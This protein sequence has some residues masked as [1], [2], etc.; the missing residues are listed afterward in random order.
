MSRYQSPEHFTKERRKEKACLHRYMLLPGSHKVAF[1]PLCHLFWIILIVSMTRLR[2]TS[3]IIKQTCGYVCD[4]ITRGDLLWME[5]PR[6]AAV[7][8]GLKPRWHINLNE[9]NVKKINIRTFYLSISWLGGVNSFS[10]LLM[11]WQDVQFSF[12]WITL[13]EC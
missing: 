7:S 6:L 11:F 2:H 1:L 5:V 4:L 13:N 9:K 8:C 10:L 3:N 12:N